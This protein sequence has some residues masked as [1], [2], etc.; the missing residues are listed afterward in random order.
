[1][2]ADRFEELLC[3]WENG[4]ASREDLREME[5]LLRESA[6]LR[7]ALL[8]RTLLEVDLHETYSGEIAEAARQAPR[9]GPARRFRAGRLAVAWAAAVLLA[10]TAGTLFFMPG[11]TPGAGPRRLD[12]GSVVAFAPGSRFSIQGPRDDARQVVELHEGAGTF[13]VV[14][15]TLAF[16]VK[17]PRGFVTA[18]DADFE[19]EIPRPGG[20]AVRVTRGTVTAS[21]G[22]ERRVLDSGERF[23]F[24][25][26][27]P[28]PPPPER[29]AEPKERGETPREKE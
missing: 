17:T 28:G 14:K 12:D 3:R 15:G 1:M 10:V 27:V 8:Q 9:P 19:V 7:K 4:A 24:E 26:I 29:P 5:G 20:L 11:A 21:H 13:R 16:Q 18:S 22:E 23:V 6:R 2:S 25:T